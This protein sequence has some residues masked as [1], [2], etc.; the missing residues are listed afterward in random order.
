MKNGSEERWWGLVKKMKA[1]GGVSLWG[2]VGLLNLLLPAFPFFSIFWLT[3][4]LT[5]L[6]CNCL[7]PIMD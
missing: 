7:S 6:S 3:M 2:W 4:M 5:A 1:A